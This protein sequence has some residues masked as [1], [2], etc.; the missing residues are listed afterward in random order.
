VNVVQT[1]F[2]YLIAR[3]QVEAVVGRTL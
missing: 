3:A 1:R 2:N